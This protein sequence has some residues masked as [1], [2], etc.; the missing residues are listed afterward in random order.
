LRFEDLRTDPSTGS[1]HQ[2]TSYEPGEPIRLS[3]RWRRFTP[4]RNG[5]ASG[6]RTSFVLYV[7]VVAAGILAAVVVAVSSA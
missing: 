2:I 7:V 6:V 1:I 4:S 5:N 3:G